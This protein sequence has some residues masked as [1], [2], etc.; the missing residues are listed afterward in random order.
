MLKV[1]VTTMRI[2][3]YIGPLRRYKTPRIAH[4][5]RI[6]R[7]VLLLNDTLLSDPDAPCVIIN[8]AVTEAHLPDGTTW[9]IGGTVWN[10]DR[11]KLANRAYMIYRP[12][13]ITPRL[14]GVAD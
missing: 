5:D 11:A 8:G 3:R 1:K 4:G 13:T 2:Y 7:K 6:I 9:R 14:V 12:K 10:R